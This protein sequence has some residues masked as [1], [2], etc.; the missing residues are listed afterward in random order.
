VFDAQLINVL[1][2]SQALKTNILSMSSQE[3]KQD[4][5]SQAMDGC[6]VRHA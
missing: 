4:H 5:L 3:I 6:P 2:L 1:N